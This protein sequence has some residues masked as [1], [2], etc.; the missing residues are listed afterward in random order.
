ML[1]QVD[2]LDLRDNRLTDAGLAPILA[3]VCDEERM[4]AIASEHAR[5]PEVAAS[6]E[7]LR[8]HLRGGGGAPWVRV[9]A[10]PLPFH[11]SASEPPQTS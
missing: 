1:P 11:A 7:G 8:P 4:M 9:G 2:A 5:E 3:A 10:A 6:C